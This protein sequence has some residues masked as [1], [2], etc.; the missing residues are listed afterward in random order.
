MSEELFLEIGI[1]TRCRRNFETLSNEM[2]KIYKTEG[3]VMSVR[4][5]PI[6]YSL[7]HKGPISIA[8][9]QKLTGLS[10]SAVSQTVKKLVTRNVL[11]QRQGVDARTK[12]I[13]FTGEGRDLIKKLEPVWDTSKIAMTGLLQENNTNLLDAFEDFERALA[14]KPFTQRYIESKSSKKGGKVELIPYD[15]KYKDDW[16]HINQQWIEKYFVMEHEDIINLQ[17][18][19]EN[20]LLKGGEIYFGM[21]DGK[22]VGVIALKHDSGTRFELSKIGVLP[23]AQGHGIAK[24]MVKKIIERY[25]ARGG[26]ELFLETN[27]VLTPAI[28][29]YKK[30]GFKEVPYFET[31]Y[32][33]ADYFMVLDEG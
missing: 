16:C 17:N 24:L 1:G 12:I 21:L 10:H 7:H 6:V 32:D 20:V 14:E 25:K 9:I 30:M 31:P 18:P 2:D 3:V 28:S 19:E 27:S 8:E 4:E 26:T 22:P 23:K 13:D 15:I 11:R 33:R 29:L 5:F